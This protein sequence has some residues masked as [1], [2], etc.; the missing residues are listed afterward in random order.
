MRV[1][2]M[3]WLSPP[4]A[5]LSTE[6][7]AL[8]AA[9]T[10]PWSDLV[11]LANTR[12]DFVQTNRLDKALARAS[13]EAA[14]G[15]AW[16]SLN[17]AVLGSSTVDHLLPA[18]RVAALR[19]NLHVRTLVGDYGMY[20]Q[21]I[22]DPDSALW[23]FRPDVL[24][25]AF[26][27]THLFGRHDPGLGAA[28]AEALLDSVTGRIT[29]LWEQ[30]RARM[31]GQIIQQTV[32]PVFHTLIGSNEHR[33]PGSVA[34]LV[35]RL[36]R[37]LVEAAAQSGVD[38]LD[39]DAA[40]L[41]D[42]LAAWHDPV[43]WHRGKQEIS[44]LATP[45]YGDLVMRLVAAQQGRSAKCLVLDLDNTLWGGVIGDDGL[46]GLRLGQGSAL[47][48]AY[49][50]FQSHVRALAQRGVILAVCSKNDL[51][52]AR[53][54]F[55]K[56]PD[57]VLKLDDIACFVA[58]WNDKAANIR[59]IAER[60]NIGIDALVFVDDNPFERNIVRR[61][62]PSV[63]VPEMPEDPALYAQCLADAG[64][65]EA[66]RLTQEDLERGG[67]YRANLAR[68]DL[69]ASHTDLE[70]YLK[71]LAMELR[72]QPFD[73][74][75]LQRVVQLINK[76]NQFNLTTRRYTENDVLA[77]MHTPGALT[78]QLRL[79]D[80]FGD[81]G[82]IGIVIG[83]PEGPV[84]RLDTWLMSCRVLGRQVEEATMNLVAAEAVRL[85]ATRLLGEYL[86]TKKNGM[87]RDHYRNLGFAEIE[88]REDGATV[89]SLDLTQ[90]RPFDTFIRLTRSDT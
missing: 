81:N 49:V 43:L 54:P 70:G 89:W 64:Y 56:H 46:E 19:R 33:L 86:P 31:T 37:R 57:M 28:E 32:L 5:N 25:L 78:L 3:L 17:L 45:A 18:L 14:A 75:G 85:G 41:R 83:K 24:L 80:A 52:N 2:D 23:A 88:A 35:S 21:S 60:L 29:A 61:E 26:D 36:N 87:V 84:I 82:I 16:R 7:R 72:W 65:F 13:T 79:L 58:N 53:S 6:L 51:E 34:T 38:I 67:Q 59:Q 62:L 39:L 30:A 68:E 8:A 10:P 40:V 12:L 22:Q 69:R 27:A 20:R 4:P 47:G 9:P 1:L 76:T 77:I 90:F 44:P 15:G 48:E 73:R 71:S 11:R 66:L 74:L 55:E 42:G 63:C 50:A